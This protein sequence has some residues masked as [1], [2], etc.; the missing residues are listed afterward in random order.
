MGKSTAFTARKQQL[1]TKI[2][3][4]R[5]QQWNLVSSMQ[6]KGYDINEDTVE[7]YNRSLELYK[8]YDSLVS[9]TVNN[10]E[11]LKEL[12]WLFND[13]E[14]RNNK[15]LNDHIEWLKKERYGN[16]LE[17]EKETMDIYFDKNTQQEMN[18]CLFFILS[19][20][21]PFILSFIIS[22]STG[23][24]YNAIAVCAIFD[25]LMVFSILIHYVIIG[26]LNLGT[27]SKFHKK[28]E[29]AY[30][31]TNK[32]CPFPTDLAISAASYGLFLAM[33]ASNIK[34]RFKK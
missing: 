15:E 7:E 23:F 12:G 33:T 18:R 9:T 21:L 6:T 17:F 14:L 32:K 22:D 29:E 4:A 20:I 30:S 24:G 28:E 26:G 27:I 13:G 25:V 3:A 34:K 10:E 5:E 8:C 2:I 11:D 19:P 16:S 1:L 31:N